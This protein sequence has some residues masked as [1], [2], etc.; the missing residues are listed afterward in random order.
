[1]TLAW[2]TDEIDILRTMWAR[3][4]PVRDICAALGT[5]NKNIVIGKAHRLKLGIHPKGSPPNPDKSLRNKPKPRHRRKPVLAGR[6]YPVEIGTEPIDLQPDQSPNAVSL[7]EVR[8]SQCRYPLNNAGSGFM[9]CG[10]PQQHG[11]SYCD[12]HHALCWRKPEP[13][14]RRRAA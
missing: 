10:S 3:G 13:T 12:R 8:D 6:S 9:F 7:L 4:E 5:G 2:S 14:V 11:S 1:M